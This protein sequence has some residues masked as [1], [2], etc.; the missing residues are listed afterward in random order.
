MA[1]RLPIYIIH[2]ANKNTLPD[3]TNILKHDVIF[4]N[5]SGENNYCKML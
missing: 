5:L 3:F 2:P 1:Q 4:Y